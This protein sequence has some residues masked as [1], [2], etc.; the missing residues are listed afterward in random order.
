MGSAGGAAGRAGNGGGGGGGRTLD[1][2][3][4]ER[5]VRAARRALTE[6]V[7]GGRPGPDAELESR[8]SFRSGVFVTLTERGRLRGCIGHPA[9]DMRL[10]SAVVDSAVSAGTSDPR[11]DPVSP[12]ELG[13]IAVEVTVLSEPE[14]IR[15]DSPG[16]RVRHVRV[17]RDGLIVRSAR[18]S[19]L[20]LPQVAAEYGWGPREFL[21]RT[22]E[23]A[24]LSRDCWMDP[25]VSVERFGGTVFAEDGPNGPVSARPI[26]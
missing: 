13:G 12:G 1:A 7:A 11:F 21:E 3:D 19:G 18:G 6:A 22:C 2:S 16:D 5:L 15:A 24:G 20:L 9:P 26:A 10:C 14:E 4:G 23:K 8:F 25:S 17:G